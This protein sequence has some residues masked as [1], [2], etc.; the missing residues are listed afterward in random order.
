MPKKSAQNNVLYTRQLLGTARRLLVKARRT[1][2]TPY[3]LSLRQAAFLSAISELGEKATLADLSRY[4]SRAVNTISSQMT[5]ME[6]DGYI[7]KV[8]VNPKSK[9]LRFELTEKGTSVHKYA[10]ENKALK[11]ILGAIPEEERQRLN[12]SLLKI[13]AEADKYNSAKH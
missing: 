8:R 7:K 1:E 3:N 5:E 11:T 13:M 4:H 6:K 10:K 2:L 12:A 9:Q